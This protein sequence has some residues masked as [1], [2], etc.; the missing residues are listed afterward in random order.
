MKNHN[1]ASKDVNLT[2]LSG[3]YGKVDPNQ[4]GLNVRQGFFRL[5][6][7]DTSRGLIGVLYLAEV[8]KQSKGFMGGSE[9]KLRLLAYQRNDQTWVSEQSDDLIPAEQACA[10]GDGALVMVNLDGSRKLQDEPQPAG[11]Q[12]VADLQKFSRLSDKVK[13]QEEEIEGWKQ[14]LTIQSNELNRR[15]MEMEERWDEL[16]NMEEELAAL[17]KQRQETATAKEEL[18]KLK[19]DFERNQAELQG[20]WEHL[21]GEQRKLEE[22]QGQVQPTGLDSEQAGKIQELV[23]YLESTVIPLDSLQEQL[24]LV[25]EGVN[26]QQASLHGY[27]QQLEEQKNQAQ[28]QQAQVEQEQEQ[29]NQR[30]QSL[31]ELVTDLDQAKENLHQQQQDLAVKEQLAQLQTQHLQTQQQLQDS[32][33]KL[34]TACGGR[35]G[36]EVVDVE[37][38]ENMPLEELQPMVDNLQR[39]LETQMRFVKDQEEEL[40]LENQ[41]IE[42]LQ[43]KFD[44]A[45]EYDRLSIEQELA[46]IKDRYRMLDETLVGQ[47]RT[48][49]EREAIFQQHLSIL[50]RRQGIVATEGGNHA[51]AIDVTPIVNQLTQQ[52]QQQQEILESIEGAVVQLQQAVESGREVV[53][54]KESERELQQQQLQELEQSWQPRKAFVTELW[55]RVE[56]YQELLQSW[57]DNLQQTSQQ[58]DSFTEILQQLQQ[59][60]DYQLQAIGSLQEL[61]SS[62]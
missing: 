37:A 52:Q 30:Q 16:E 47:R 50:R 21:K 53:K 14:S 35:G 39:D 9:T 49:R 42:K 11:S 25:T 43:Q 33:N 5:I 22:L 54:H 6:V 28:E 55:L 1:F 13:E 40:T 59:T 23:A 44:A 41:D 58:L 10:F 62:H 36:G 27:W 2:I 56:I 24:H 46:E 17:E 4:A 61:V 31:Q 48:L 51:Q 8:K 29:I 12:L 18:A 26:N 7:Q 34:A 32:F 3:N 20:A 60:K 19:E 45:S 38:L 15:E 57:Q